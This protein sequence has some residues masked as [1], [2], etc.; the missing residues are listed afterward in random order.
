MAGVN[1]ES[2]EEGEEDLDE[3]EDYIKINRDHVFAEIDYTKRKTNIICSLGPCSSETEDI[4]KLMDAGMCIA[5]I[6]IA[7][8]NEKS[9]AR[10]MK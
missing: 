4:V 2:N 8:M 6:N 5:R 10:L 3:Y 7:H 9:I 1:G